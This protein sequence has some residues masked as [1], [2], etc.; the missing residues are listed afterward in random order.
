MS[1]PLWQY[2][3]QPLFDP[4]QPP[5]LLPQQFSK[6]YLIE[7][8]LIRRFQ[9]INHLEWCWNLQLKTLIVINSSHS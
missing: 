7:Q 6:Y 8:Q 1:F 9:H 3:K 4:Q 5:I 2:L